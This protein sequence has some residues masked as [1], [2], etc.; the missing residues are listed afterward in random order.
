MSFWCQPHE[1]LQNKLFHMNFHIIDD[2]VRLE[3]IP[4]RVLS[5]EDTINDASIPTKNLRRYRVKFSCMLDE[6][7][8][9]VEDFILTGWFFL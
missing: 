9:K 2:G 4:C 7:G 6:Q 8:Y 3:N 5:D 1:E